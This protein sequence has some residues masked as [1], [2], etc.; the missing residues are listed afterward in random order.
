MNKKIKWNNDRELI[1]N[2]SSK[3]F[4]MARPLSIAFNLC[5][6]TICIVAIFVC[7]LGPFFSPIEK[8]SWAPYGNILGLFGLYGALIIGYSL[9]KTGEI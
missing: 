1:R 3:I 8:W 7:I 6:V 5:A 9:G 2:I 4:L